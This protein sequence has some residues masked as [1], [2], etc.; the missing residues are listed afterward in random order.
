MSGLKLK[1]ATHESS[2]LYALHFYSKENKTT[3]LRGITCIQTD[4][5]L[6][7]CNNKFLEVEQRRVIQL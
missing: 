2:F 1:Q 5:A 4:D 6:I 7:L 3:F